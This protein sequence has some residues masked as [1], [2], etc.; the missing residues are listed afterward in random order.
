MYC[1]NSEQFGSANHDVGCFGTGLAR[2]VSALVK[3]P[4]AISSEDAG[5]L[6]CGG[7]TVWGPL[8]HSGLLPGNRIGV[9]G[10]GGLGHLAIQF[11]AKLGYDVAVFSST[12][13]KKEEAIKFGATE[14][15]ATAGL[16]KFEGIDPIDHLLIT[17][18]A[19]PDFAL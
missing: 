10:I 3:I 18:S 8:V 13:N 9:V 2:D 6:M 16:T 4:D 17:T 5:P 11:A 19:Q 7:A 12:E 15:H 14:F 1:L